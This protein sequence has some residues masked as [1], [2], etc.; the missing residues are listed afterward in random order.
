MKKT[1]EAQLKANKK[2]NA[3]HANE[4]RYNRYRNSAESFIQPK[5]PLQ[6][7]TMENS[8]RYYDDLRD[9]ETLIHKRITELK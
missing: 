8:T 7:E 3:E 9:L 2:W 6:R 1:S 4:V 5:S